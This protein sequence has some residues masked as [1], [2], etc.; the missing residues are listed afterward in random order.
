M[1]IR[2]KFLMGAVIVTAL[3]GLAD[4]TPQKGVAAG[5]IGAGTQA[6]SIEVHGSAN[7]TGDRFHVSLETEGPSTITTTLVDYTAGGQNGWH[8]HPGMVIVTL[9]KGSIEWYDENCK[10][11]IHNAGETWMEGSKIHYLRVLGT[12]TTQFVTTFIVAQGQP[13]RIDQHAPPCAAALGIDQ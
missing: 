10:L 13:N 1:K 9:T 2:T 3:A 8:S 12:T 7:T 5:V 11:T 4:A 6:D